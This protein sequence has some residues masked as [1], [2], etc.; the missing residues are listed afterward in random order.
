MKTRV[1][2]ALVLGLGLCAGVAN[3]AGPKDY[4][5]GSGSVAPGGVV[6]DFSF[7]AESDPAGGSPKGT[8][9]WKTPTFE[10]DATVT[11]MSVVTIPGFERDALLIGDILRTSGAAPLGD[12]LSFQL[13]DTGG[14]VASSFGDFFDASVIPESLPEHDCAPVGALGA[15]VTGGDITIIDE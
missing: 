10:I 5:K 8:M 13:T 7:N 15:H 11:C 14:T 4:A 12:G 3:A 6:Q 2:C 9:H 1:I